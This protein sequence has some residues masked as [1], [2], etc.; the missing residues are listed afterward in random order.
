MAQPVPAAPTR[1]TRYHQWLGQIA[2]RRQD[3]AAA[4]THFEAA[5]LAY[6]YALG[7]RLELA[8]A[9]AEQ[10]NTQAA[11]ASLRALHAYRGESPLPP[12]AA[13][14]LDTLER[15]LTNRQPLSKSASWYA[16]AQGSLSITQGFDSNANLGSR[17]RTISLNLFDQISDQAVLAD[18]SRAQSSHYSRL[19]LAMSLPASTLLNKPSAA[20]WYLQGGFGAQQYHDLDTLHRQ[21][22][23]LSAEWRPQLSPTRLAATLQQQY[24]AGIGKARY[25][26]IDYRRLFGEHW[27]AEAGLQ[28]QRE[29]I[30][31]DS[32][33]LSAGLWREW[34]GMLLW[35]NAGWQFRSGRDSGDTW[36]LRLGAQTPDW[37]WQSMRTRAYLNLERRRDTDLYNYVFFGDVQRQETTTRLGVRSRLPLTDTFDLLL[38]AQWEE[39]QASLELFESRRWS[40]DATLRWRW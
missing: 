35:G 39:T 28:W 3:T 9:Y 31:R 36:R 2:L 33:R 5:V 20:A 30:G 29:P 15:Q 6:P 13:Q 14:A 18:A 34:H 12:A 1:A 22:A 24:V 10:G 21:D 37:R 17:H 8:L 16:A 19:A 7:A 40:L 11:R 38:D 25:V 23:Y 32:H 26:D 4:I 27:M